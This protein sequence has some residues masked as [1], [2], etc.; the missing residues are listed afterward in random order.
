VAHDARGTDTLNTVPPAVRRLVQTVDSPA[1]VADID[2]PEPFV[3]AANPA[4]FAAPD[5]PA[6]GASLAAW[7]GEEAVVAIVREIDDGAGDGVWSPWRWRLVEDHDRRWLLCE[8]PAAA[9]TDQE[10]VPDRALIAAYEA[11]L[12]VASDLS[13]DGVLQ[14]IVDLAREVVPARYAALGVADEQGR[15]TRFIT[16]G[17]TPEERELIGPLPEGHGLLGEL[18]REGKPLLVPDIKADPRSVGFPADHP[19]MRTLLGAPILLG[20]LPVGNLYLSERIDDCPFDRDDLAAVQV[21]AAHAASAIDRAGLYGKLGESRARAEEQR[22]QLR[23]IL[24][25]L[26]SGVLLQELPDG[27][28]E[29]ANAAAVDLLLGAG[30]PPRMLPV[31][32]RDYQVR[33]ADGTPLPPHDVPVARALRGEVVRNH[34]LTLE[35]W[36]GSRLPVLVQAAPLRDSTGTVTRAVVVLQDV[37]RLREAEQLKD[38][39][40][41]LV[42]HEF[43]TP[44][45]AIHGGAHLLAN[46][47]QDLDEGTRR[48]LL[49]DIVTESER[50]DG[51]LRNMLSLTA[52]LAGRLS[53]ATE[54]LL[55]GPL[56]RAVAAETAPRAPAHTFIVDVPAGLPPAEGDPDLLSQVLR[57]LYENAVKYAPGGGEVR[58]AAARQGDTIVIAVTDQGVGIAAEHVPFVFERFRRP[59]ADPTI[60][61]MGLG[62]YLSRHLVEAQN[63]QIAVTSLGPGQGT[64]FTVTL[65]I[66]GVVESAGREAS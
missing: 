54:P 9:L 29:L 8:R 45:T 16:S 41:S 44:L 2:Q 18:I 12:A 7:L 47:G 27:A 1:I 11:A 50:L 56:A 28:I 61:G 34:Q 15:L 30:A 6:E 51:M 19:P 59:G 4:A 40:L 52:I 17:L 62:L 26:P 31:E 13:L 38:D 23:V 55:V 49:V 53:A 43:R 25:N 65:P 5:A 20:D 64:T 14:R 22:D 37:T 36:D 10:T 32:G 63:G 3:L 58:T 39:F 21:L 24:D 33:H 35:R 48:E 46:Q 60:R 66:A 57:N 42:S